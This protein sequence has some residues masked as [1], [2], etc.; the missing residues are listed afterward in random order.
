MEYQEY[1]VGIAFRFLQP[2]MA[3]PR[4]YHRLAWL[5]EKAGLSAESLNTSLPDDARGMRRRLR[6]ICRIQKMSTFAVGAMINRGV[7]HMPDSEVFVNVGV[8]RGFTFLSGLIGNERKRCV[9]IDNFSEFGGPKE[10]FL[11]RFN[12]YKGANHS[13][14]AMDYVTYFAKVHQ[15]PIG[16]YL[17][18]GHHGYD[19]Q[20]QGLQVAEPFFSRNCIVMVD[21]TNWDE[22]RRA[23][24]DFI[25]QSPHRYKILL[26]ATTSCNRH[27]TLWNGV[28]VF[29]RVG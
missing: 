5:L 20:L 1:I 3:V 18:D 4:G 2:H 22:P 14:H 6:E 9:G 27:P 8:W 15:G 28:I 10:E 7:S 19:S 13:F 23:T 29:Q 21:D 12:R 25:A 24:M 26:D 17:Y 16:Y 11:E